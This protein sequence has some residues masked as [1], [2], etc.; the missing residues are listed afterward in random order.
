MLFMVAAFDKPGMLETR[1]RLRKAHMT[2]LSALGSRI[3][4]G[5][6]MLNDEEQPLGSL[7]VIEA[8]D[9]S[10]IQALVDADPFAKAGVFERVD[11]RPWR[12]SVGA[13]VKT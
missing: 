4:V 13:W 12:A 1:T 2:Y 8:K 7:L 10:S 9:R 11:I 6:A 5:G 3:K